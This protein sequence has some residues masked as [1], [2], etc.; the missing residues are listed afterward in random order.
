LRAEIAEHPRSAQ[1]EEVTGPD[2][3][4]IGL[5]AGSGFSARLVHRWSYQPADGR[6]DRRTPRPEP[7]LNVRWEIDE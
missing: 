6:Q 4:V 5:I 3:E 1:D 2:E 7:N